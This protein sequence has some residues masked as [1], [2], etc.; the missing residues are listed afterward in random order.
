MLKKIITL[1]STT[2][3]FS[4]QAN[5]I[6]I[7]SQKIL[8][9]SELFKN[10]LIDYQKN[11]NKEAFNPKGNYDSIEDFRNTLKNLNLDNFESPIK[12]P[13]YD[14]DGVFGLIKD[15]NNLYLTIQSD[16]KTLTNDICKELNNNEL[17]TIEPF[18]LTESI[19]YLNNYYNCFSNEK[20]SQNLYIYKIY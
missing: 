10:S 7:D 18:T 6:L 1:L 5:N 4:I 19:K 3:A 11:N 14:R 2:I 17:K 13:Y 12:N 15:N 20:N 8:E 9:Q 16:V